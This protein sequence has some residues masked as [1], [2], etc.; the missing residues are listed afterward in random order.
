MAVMW[1][2]IVTRTGDFSYTVDDSY[3]H[4]TLSKN[5]ASHLTFGIVPGEFSATSSSILWTLM[6]ALVFAVTGAHAWIAGALG[7]LF[8]AL[9]IE[10]AN[11][12][13]KETGV[14]AITR[15]VMILLAV[16]YAPF[17][18]IISTGMEH[19]FHIWTMLGLFACLMDL[20]NG[21]KTWPGML[22][23]WAALAA[24]ARYESLFALPPLMI[25]L[26]FRKKWATILEL[27]GG[28]ALPVL[29]FAAYSLYHGGYPLPN[30]LMLKGNFD[31]TFQIKCFR[32]MLE[33]QHVLMLVIYLVIATAV[34]F[35]SRDDRVKKQV[36]LPLS[37]LVLTVIHLQ[38]AQL[39][40]FY[41]Y[42]GYIV[43][44]G[45]VA[46]APM[47]VPLHGRLR[48]LSPVVSL[49][50]YVLLFFTTLPLLWRCQRG[51][52]EIVHAAANI[53]D[54]QVQMARVVKHL[55]KDAR[56]AV[57]DLGAVSFFT[58][59]RVLDLWGLGDN[60]LARA[61]RERRYGA[62]V[63]KARMEEVGTEFV[64]YYPSWFG[65]PDNLPS[66]LI[67]VETW[68]LGDNLI[69]GSDTVL[70]CGT[71]PEAAAKLRIALDQYRAEKDHNPLSTNRMT[72]IAVD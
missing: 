52:G 22:F 63:L 41:R 27:G 55:G 64:V 2:A 6:M 53:H 8:G 13:L 14:G 17:L 42:E 56:V 36:W 19:S 7:T 51:T 21:R 71:S 57:N 60:G 31:S 4:G 65:E 68:V 5:I 59:A 3:I 35:F 58:E 1:G 24:G 45:M 9:A 39:G 33:N 20:S 29:G 16:A 30:S 12:L 18:P 44:L 50:I 67:P 26:F 69:C 28:M 11:H 61:K 34:A 10:R 49:P 72:P 70:F 25:W 46:A 15:A 32:V 43:V 47:L 62:A 38:L 66:T 40:W 48:K 23:L 54:Q 37:A